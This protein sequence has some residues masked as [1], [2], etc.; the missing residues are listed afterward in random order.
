MHRK[1][2]YGFLTTQITPKIGCVVRYSELSH[3]EM[4]E[5]FLFVK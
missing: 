3:M 5:R 2:R 1:D 4:D